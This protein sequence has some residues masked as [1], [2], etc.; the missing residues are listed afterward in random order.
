MKSTTCAAV[1]ESPLGVLTLYGNGHALTALRISEKPLANK[2]ELDAGARDAVLNK[3]KQQLEKY[4]KGKLTSFDV[5]LEVKGTPF[6]KKV[7]K[8]LSKI[9][10]GKTASYKDIA[11]MVGNPKACRAVGTANG[12]NPLCVLVPCH[13]VISNDGS[14]GGYTGGLS[15]KRYLLSLEAEHDASL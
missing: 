11:M 2:T 14:I 5:P 12:K 3:T 10:Y 1:M 7:W 15:K 4:F 9:P 8:A 6:Q 13:R